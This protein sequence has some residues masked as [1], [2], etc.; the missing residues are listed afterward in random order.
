M[1]NVH[2]LIKVHAVRTTTTFD[3]T[4][5]WTNSEHAAP[6]PEQNIALGASRTNLNMSTLTEEVPTINVLL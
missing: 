2:P 3:E 5:V 4:C 6:H 1:H